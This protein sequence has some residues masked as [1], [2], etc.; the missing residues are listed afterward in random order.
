MKNKNR[1]T[2]NTVGGREDQF[3]TTPQEC[4]DPSQTGKKDRPQK[5][6]HC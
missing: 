4:P 3:P 2:E 1:S 5:D 6:E